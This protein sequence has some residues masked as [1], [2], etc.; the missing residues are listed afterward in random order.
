VATVVHREKVT[1]AFVK[2]A[3]GYFVQGVRL[4]RVVR[5]PTGPNAKTVLVEDCY[6]LKAEEMDRAEVLKATVAKWPEGLEL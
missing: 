1:V 4:L 5:P 2:V 3:G 6:T